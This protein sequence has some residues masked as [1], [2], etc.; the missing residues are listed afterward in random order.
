VWGNTVARK[1]HVGKHCSNPQCFLFKKK[2]TKLNYQPA[3]YEKKTKIDK[4]SSGKKKQRKKKKN[5][6]GKHCSN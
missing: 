2:T 4:D 3:Q 5:H 1:N 6:M